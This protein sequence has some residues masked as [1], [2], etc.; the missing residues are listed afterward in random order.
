MFFLSFIY[1]FFGPEASVFHFSQTVLHILNA[2]ILFLFLKRFFKKPLALIIS[3]IFLVHPINS[4]VVFYVSNTQEA[5]F[6][7]FGIL[8]LWLASKARSKKDVILASVCVFFSLL[9]KETGA[10]FLIVLPV[11]IWLFNKKHF[12]TL[13]GSLFV[14]LAAYLSLRINAV[15]LFTNPSNTPISLLSFP[16][17]LLNIP[18]IFFFYLKTFIFP[19]NLAHFY[20]WAYQEI[21]LNS[22]FLLLL[23]DLLAIAAMFYGAIRLFKK[24]DKKYFNIYIFFALWFFVGILLHLQLV[25]LDATVAEHWFYFPIVGL[26][27]MTG[28]FFEATQVDFSTKRNFSLAILVLV[29]LLFRT[30]I[31]SF[32]WRNELRLN[33]RDI[34][35]APE[36]YALENRI[37]FQLTQLERYEEARAHAEK[38]IE[39]YPTYISYNNL[40]LSYLGE[41]N[42]QKAEDAFRKALTFGD[43]PSTYENLGG[44]YLASGSPKTRSFLKEATEKFPR[45]SRLWLYLSIS[46][47]KAGMVEEAKG[48]IS[49]AYELDQSQE[50]GL[51]YLDIMN[52]RPLQVEFKI[53]K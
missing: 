22:F 26:L 43:Y 47:Y 23:I 46:E 21:T 28:T 20:Q 2:S 52:D 24:Y 34:R 44:L 7:F 5:L 25:P 40:G 10:L 27:G 8:A 12:Y 31:R 39:I 42:Y 3:L 37:S 18:A 9:S 4:E 50:I 38:S 14:A 6:F 19:L 1:T 32:D 41:V 36:S 48:S 33:M 17:R 16:E 35:V 49:K 53:G 11:Y 45:D 51:V 30:F 13:L 29:L 15:G